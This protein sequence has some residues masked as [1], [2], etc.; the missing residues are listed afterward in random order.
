M[1]KSG[2]V[3]IIKPTGESSSNVVCKIKKILGIKKVGHLGTLDPAA[4]GVLPIAFGKATKFFDYFLT[5]DKEYIAVVKF[6]VET[7]TLD[8]FG[9]IIDAKDKMV[10][11]AEIQAVLNEFVGNIK[12]IPP[13]YS[14]IKIDGKKACDLARE[15]KDVDIKAREIKVYSL[16][17]LNQIEDNVFRFKVHCSAGTYIRTLFSDIAKRLGTISTTTVIIRTKSGLFDIENS[18]ALNEFESAKEFLSIEE[19]FK[20]LKTIDVSEED[21]KK[22]LL[23]G[24]KLSKDEID[25]DGDENFFIKIEN[26]LVGMYHFEKQKLV[27]D[28]FLSE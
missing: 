10:S 25:F 15:G 8:S 24:V 26:S 5:K 21:L 11:E 13:K 19:V 1:I 28:V 17:L 2:F 20:G 4:S 12:Q 27:C 7:D 3:N 14:A 16:K 23:N 22:K 9:Q 6:G 18:V